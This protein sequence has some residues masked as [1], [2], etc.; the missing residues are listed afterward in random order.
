MTTRQ[1]VMF[2]FIDAAG[3]P[4]GYVGIAFARDDKELFWTIDEFGDPY[5]VELANLKQAGMC[6]K[7]DVNNGDIEAEINSSEVEITGHFTDAVS[8]PD[9]CKWKKADWSLLPDRDDEIERVTP[10]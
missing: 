9:T 1:A 6:I 4:T 8:M 5:S 2:R 10:K 7:C 3:K